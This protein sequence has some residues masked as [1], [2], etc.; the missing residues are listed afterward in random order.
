GLTCIFGETPAI[1][2][3]YWSPNTLVCLLPPS[4]TPGPVVV[5]FKEFPI[6]LT[7]NSEQEVV[8]FN[9]NDD[10]DR[11]LMELALQ[12]VGM[13]MTGKL[14]DARNIAMRIVGGTDNNQNSGNNSNGDMNGMQHHLSSFARQASRTDNFE[15][16]VVATLAL[17]DA[18]ETEYDSISLRNRQQHTMLHMAVMLGYKRLCTYLIEKDI[19][20]DIQDK[21]GFT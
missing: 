11:A 18:F 12:V 5:S 7:D 19:D 17:M 10:S 20:V 4:P 3:Q 15:E 6:N 21:H 14:E 8:F 1:P 13:K 16:H 9:Y 2:T